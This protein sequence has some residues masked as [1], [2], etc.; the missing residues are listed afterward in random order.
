MWQEI[1]IFIPENSFHL[2]CVSACSSCTAVLQKPTQSRARFQRKQISCH[3]Q[4]AKSQLHIC[5]DKRCISHSSF[6]LQSLD[7]QFKHQLYPRAL[8]SCQFFPLQVR[9]D[10]LKLEPICVAPSKK[11]EFIEWISLFESRKFAKCTLP[12]LLTATLKSKI[13]IQAWKEEFSIWSSAKIQKYE[14]NRHKNDFKYLCVICSK[15]H[16]IWCFL[17]IK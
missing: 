13:C 16:S 5:G 9:R 3:N 15:I 6:P 1:F 17:L 8:T 7:L 10:V 11:S 14:R 2:V 4:S 12:L